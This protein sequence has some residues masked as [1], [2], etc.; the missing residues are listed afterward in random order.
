[1]TDAEWAL[2]EPE[3]PPPACRTPAG[4]RPEKHDR[5][6][7]VDTIRYITDN[8]A[9]WRALPHDF[10]I[11]WQTVYG[12]FARWNK[13]G[14]VEKLRDL[15][16]AKI[17][18][19]SKRCPNA[20][21]LMIDSQ[22]V[23]ASETVSK[24]TRGFD[25]GKLINGRKRHIVVDGGG[26][27]VDVM[28]T[29]ADVTDRNAARILLGR[30][31]DAHPEIVVVWADQGYT[32]ELIAWAKENL[33]ITMIVVKRPKNAVGF[34]LLPKR[35]VVERTFGWIMRARRNVRDH[36]RLPSHSEAHINW[37]AITLMTRRLTRTKTTRT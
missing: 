10:A 32:G 15:L 13:L 16:R 14:I 20:V 3:L 34:I 9:K 6:R 19:R 12:F 2:I 23:K 30:L 4:G 17:R 5:R 1:M 8:G 33:G 26:L 37:T 27:P 29:A 18:V 31:H 22:S 11:P 28:V 36:E 35:W 21:A 24:A 25:G 7:I